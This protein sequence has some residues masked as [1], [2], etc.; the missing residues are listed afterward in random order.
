[1]ARA[2]VTGATGFIGQNLVSALLARGDE[3]TCLVRRPSAMGNLEKARVHLA[4]GDVTV[5][6]SLASPIADVEIVYHI[7]G[8]TKAN[9]F[10]GFCSVNEVG[11]RNVIEAASRRTTPPVVIVL[12]SLAAAGPMQEPRPRTEADT[13]CPISNYGRSKRAGE[14]A[15]ES[16]ASQVPITIVRPP[17]VLGPGDVA[18]FTLFRSIRRFRCYTVLRKPRTVSVVHVADLVQ[19]I[20]AAAER[21]ERLSS[22]QTD[23]SRGYYFLAADE[24]LTFLELGRIVARAVGR[25]YAWKI[26][27]PMATLWMAGAIG[28]ALGQL[29]RRPRYVCLDRARDVAAGH[30]SCSAE[31]AKRQLQFAPADSLENRIRQTAQWY[32]DQGWLKSLESSWPVPKEA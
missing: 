21:G 30:W 27:L 2:L 25:P 16:F 9:S 10:A 5:P 12:S 7:A 18:G 17:V 26:R 1:M 4:S 31:K 29:T 22:S 23:P 6:A 32:R 13:I 3:V 28:E 19:G 14:L 11:V 8:L 20:I 24:Q 15:A